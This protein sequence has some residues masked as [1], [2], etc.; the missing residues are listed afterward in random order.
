MQNV[1]KARNIFFITLLVIFGLLS[2]SVLSK[3]LIVLALAYVCALL[4]LPIYNRLVVWFAKKRLLKSSSSALASAVT[5]ILLIVL[6]ITPFSLIMGKIF[7][8]AQGFY[9]KVTEGGP[10]ALSTRLES[11][12]QP[13]FPD[14]KVKL[15]EVAQGISGFVVS[16]IG[17][18]FSSTF[19]IV[20]KLFLFLIAL[21]YFL[22]DKNQFEAL[23]K[24]ITPL[25][26]KDDDRIFASV[27]TAVRSILIGSLVVA[28]CQGVVTGIGFAIFG[29]P[30]PFFWGAVAGMF[31]L[32]PGVGPAL[33][34]VPGVI[35]LYVTGDTGSVAWIGQ[36]VWGIVAVG[37]IDNI[38]GPKVMN[39]GIAIHPLFILL[40][41]IGGIALFGPEGFLF[42]PLVL[43]VFVAITEAWKAREQETV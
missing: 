36:L 18:F 11:Y 1:S 31:A 39:K 32:V 30:N 35:Y 9:A 22:K 25:N 28:L 34:W 29:V 38:L 43:S 10:G 16:N 26:D 8:D 21:F 2:F 33:I 17:S 14:A 41:V 42:G 7:A 27:K 40:S 24:R 23:Y 6:I 3:F 5:L 20:L 15:N 12:I 37:L 19:D 4:V 13:Y